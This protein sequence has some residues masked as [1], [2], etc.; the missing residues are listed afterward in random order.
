MSMKRIIFMFTA[1]MIL[2]LPLSACKREELI[3]GLREA[4]VKVYTT[5]YPIQFVVEQVGGKTVS[6]ESV[7]PPG[8]DAHTFEPTTK[9]MTKI[10][11]SD[12]FIY[13]GPS[14]EGFVESAAK[15]L[16]NEAVKLVALEDYPELF[17]KDESHGANEEEHH[18]EE[19]HEDVHGHK[20]HGGIDPHI[21]I[22]PSRMVTVTQI[23]TD[24]LI[25][26]NP[27]DEELYKKNRNELVAR[28]V[29]LDHLYKNTLEKKEHKYLIVPHAAYGYWEER[30]GI[31][32][33]AVSGMSPS[34]EPSQKYLS[35]VIETAKE[36]N[37]DSVFYEQNTPDKLIDIVRE[38]INAEV[39][40]IHN[41]AVLT[42]ADKKN[43][44]DYFT[45]MEYNLNVMN[46][47]FY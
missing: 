19:H 32:Q 9:D 25:E 14:M 24:L 36:H 22:D 7:Y 31:K 21:W 40:T 12:L 17:A 1:I 35:E 45:L 29:K 15:T 4:D 10:A 30:Y 28:F 47:A 16:E 5:I 27:K 34:E 20:H 38:E 23:I 13:I 39:Y 2:A 44:E 42:E 43:E 41:L 26:L 8:V 37:I 6:V 18:E 3:S 46:E 33:I 11:T